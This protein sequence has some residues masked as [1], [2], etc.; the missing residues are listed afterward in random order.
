[1]ASKYWLKLYYDIL[2]DPK[3][4]TLSTHLRWRFV[5]CLLVAGE[6]DEEGFLPS[7]NEMAWRVRADGE[8]LDT[9][10]HE[11]A[12]YGLLTKTEGR[13]LVT[14]FAKRQAAVGATERWRQWRDRQRQQEYEQEQTNFKRDQTATQ[15]K[16]L[17]DID[18]D[19]IRIDEKITRAELPPEALP[20]NQQTAD[21]Q[22]REMI[23]AI[24]AVVK[25]TYAPGINEELFDSAAA[26]LASKGVT[27][28]QVR[29]FGQWWKSNGHYEGKPALK[30][31]LNEIDNSLPEIGTA[32]I[33]NLTFDYTE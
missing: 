12:N 17:T 2:D 4:G 33:D 30:S 26:A 9:D 32:W 22:H 14:N 19:K 21:D 25:Q 1:M 24:S 20:E 11:L 3:I 10:L 5:E 16:R 6:M 8:R 27:C 13:W 7:S 18:T 23:G 28:E 15:T 29:A 31:L